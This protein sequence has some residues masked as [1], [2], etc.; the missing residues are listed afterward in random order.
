MDFDSEG[1]LSTKH[2]SN[3][4]NYVDPWDLENYAYIRKRMEPE[5]SSSPSAAA[6]ETVD[7]SF[8]YTP[9]EREQFPMSDKGTAKY[10]GVSE[11]DFRNERFD[12][13]STAYYH[14]PYCDED[15]YGVPPDYSGNIFIFF[16]ILLLE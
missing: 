13:E 14:Q 11:V 6:G 2:S 7:S 15:L 3:P 10:A 16:K 4:R 9:F 1:T 5:V 12:A 8:Y